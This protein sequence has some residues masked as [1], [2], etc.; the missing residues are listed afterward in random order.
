MSPADPALSVV[1][2]STGE[3]TTAEAI[4]SVSASVAAAGEAVE[5]IVCWQAPQAPPP[6]PGATVLELLPVS[7]S[8][9]R[10]RG[11]EAARAPIVAFLD[12]DE[13]V[14]EGWVAAI[15]A[16]LRGPAAPSACFGPIEPRPGDTGIPHCAFT[17][18]EPRLIRGASTPPWTVGSGGNMAVDRA[19]LVAQGGFDLLLGAGTVGRSAED[20]DL[21]VGLLKRGETL[22]WSPDMV[23]FHPTKTEA[24]RLASRFPYAFGTGRLIR[25]E[26]HLGHAARQVEALLHAGGRALAH[27]DRRLLRENRANWSGFL[28]GLLRRPP[29]TSPERLLEH[30]PAELLPALG[31]GPIRPLPAAWRADP[32]FAYAYGEE[33]LLHAYVNPSA[34]LLAAVADRRAISAET[35]CAGVPRV[36]ASAAGR[37]ALWMVEERLPGVEAAA[38]DAARWYELVA[39]WAVEFGR[40]SATPLGESERFRA[41]REELLAVCPED[42]R[43]ALE[44]ALGTVAALPAAHVHGDLEAKNVLLDGDAIGIIDWEGAQARGLPGT[45]LVFLA[46]SLSSP[47]PFDGAAVAALLAGEPSAGRLRERLAAVG[48][49]AAALRP[50]LLVMLTVWA[51]DERARLAI[52]G[53]AG[54]PPPP[55]L[56]GP[57]LSR[58]APRLMTPDRTSAPR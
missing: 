15:L 9:A 47:A 48:V 58:L 25:R 20:T 8:Y 34:A 4:A 13:V 29:W 30:V 7:L 50:A 16:A 54:G 32:H 3:A 36:L 31:S 42:L 18:A 12:A 35:E 56:F 43:P 23:V 24:E 6:L 37:D 57:L 51:A 10:N 2:C 14:A 5:T 55:P 22:A 17:G 28:Q 52:V 39:D 46:L 26:R 40:P 49:D 27:R 33:L 45:D 53:K 21:I 1:V 41:R 11:V 38:R 44:A 19:A